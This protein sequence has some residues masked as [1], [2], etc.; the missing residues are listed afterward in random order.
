[1]MRHYEGRTDPAATSVTLTRA[2]LV[3]LV[4][5][6]K[7]LKAAEAD[8]ALTIEGEAGE[9]ADFLAWLDRFDFWFEI[10]EP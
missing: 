9:F 10:I 3:E 1:V 6:A 5:G 8:G 2:A 7:T 4:T